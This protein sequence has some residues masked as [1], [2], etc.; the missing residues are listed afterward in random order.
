MGADLFTILCHQGIGA[1]GTVRPNAGIY[2]E[3]IQLKALDKKG[4]CDWTWG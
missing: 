4:K 3:I 2:K 1:T